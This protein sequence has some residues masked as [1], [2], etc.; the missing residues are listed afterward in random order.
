MYG[1]VS[2][3]IALLV[4]MYLI[5]AD[6]PDRLRIQR[7]V[8]AEFSEPVGVGI[9]AGLKYNLMMLRVLLTI[10]FFSSGIGCTSLH[11]R[12]GRRFASFRQ[13]DDG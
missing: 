2:G 8:R 5:L 13:T 9:R 6:H 12:N 4:W 1:S 3:G 7:R 10:T 11:V